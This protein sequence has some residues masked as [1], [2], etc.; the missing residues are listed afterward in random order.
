[1]YWPADIQWYEAEVIKSVPNQKRRRTKTSIK[2]NMCYIIRYLMD[3]VVE[4]INIQEHL[5]RLAENDEKN[6]REEQEEELEEQQEEQQEEQEEGKLLTLKR[7]VFEGFAR[8]GKNRLIC[9]CHKMNEPCFYILSLLSDGRVSYN[10]TTYDTLNDFVNVMNLSFLNN[11]GMWYNIRYRLTHS[12]SVCLGRLRQ[13]GINLD[14][15]EK[16]KRSKK[17][18]HMRSKVK[19]NTEGRRKKKN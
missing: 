6:G 7:L 4:K 3:D 16:I 13:V 8:P 15:K 18:K 9:L 10:S 11:Y 19:K 2:T 12:R 5:I 17:G 1:M 14:I